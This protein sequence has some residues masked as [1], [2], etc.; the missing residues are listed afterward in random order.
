[1]KKEKENIDHELKEIREQKEQIE[2]LLNKSEENLNIAEEKGA[3]SFHEVENLKRQMMKIQS[4]ACADSARKE[5]EIGK[6]KAEADSLRKELDEKVRDHDETITTL[7]ITEKEN[8]FLKKDLA[9]KHNRESELKLDLTSTNSKL[10]SYV[11]E[12]ECWEREVK[13]V[14]SEIEQQKNASQSKEE[15]MERMRTRYEK[16]IGFLQERVEAL[17]REVRIIQEANEQQR[18]A[19][20][21][22]G[23]L[24]LETKDMEIDNLKLRL[25]AS[26]MHTSEKS[27]VLDI[28]KEQLNERTRE[29]ADLMEQIRMLKESYHLELGSMHAEL[30]CAQMENMLHKRGEISDSFGGSRQEAE[31]LEAIKE[32]RKESERL[33]NMLK[34]KMKEMKSLRK[35]ILSERV[36]GAKKPGYTMY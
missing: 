29:I 13:N 22:A 18:H 7:K 21:I 24:A 12:R 25:Q 17:E 11:I 10:Q 35:H 28:M 23:K 26:R 33:R 1:M 31:L 3:N 19:D 36:G 2:D 20:E 32:S 5:L 14:L 9:Q 4:S 16:E 6:L 15:K 27:D 34:N 8:E 30:K